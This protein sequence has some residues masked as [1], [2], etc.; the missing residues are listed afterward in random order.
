[1]VRFVQIIA[2]FAY[3]NTVTS[4]LADSPIIASPRK[5]LP[6]HDRYY[7]YKDNRS[8]QQK[9]ASELTKER[10]L[11][12]EIEDIEEMRALEAE[13]ARQVYEAQLAKQARDL[14]VERKIRARC[15]TFFCLSAN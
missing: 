5:R 11:E 14:E 6:K 10:W 8:P 15:N 4:L 3:A 9:M 2:Y 7:N 12:K 13:K 1:M